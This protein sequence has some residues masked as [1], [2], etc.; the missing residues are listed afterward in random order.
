MK[1][2]TINSK[3][4]VVLLVTILAIFA[5]GVAG[6]TDHDEYIEATSTPVT[7]IPY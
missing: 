6:Q 3:W 2:Q 5:V 4:I 1:R 7:R